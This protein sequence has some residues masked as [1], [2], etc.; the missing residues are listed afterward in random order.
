LHWGSGAMC[1]LGVLCDAAGL[2]RRYDEAGDHYDYRSSKKSEWYTAILPPGAAKKW[3]MTWLG[4]ATGPH[5]QISDMVDV[6]GWRPKRVANYI[7]DHRK[8]Y[9]KSLT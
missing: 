7:R 8:L 1:P 6:L 4:D 9:I 3:G 2:E 5:P